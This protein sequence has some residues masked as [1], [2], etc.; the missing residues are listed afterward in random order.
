MRRKLTSGLRH[1]KPSVV[2]QSRSENRPDSDHRNVGS[3]T[4]RREHEESERG[5]HVARDI[6]VQNAENFLTPDLWFSFLPDSYTGL[7][8]SKPF[9][10]PEKSASSQRRFHFFQ[11]TTTNLWLQRMWISRSEYDE[12][13]PSIVHR[14]CF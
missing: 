13:G 7:F 4:G 3:A 9:R 2:F 6:I 10:C 12:Y 5:E 1:A 11:Q 14:K 8:F